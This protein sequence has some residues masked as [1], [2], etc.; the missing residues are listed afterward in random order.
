MAN[1]V[2]G[3]LMCASPNRN[4]LPIKFTALAQRYALQKRKQKPSNKETAKLSVLKT[5]NVNQVQC[6]AYMHTQR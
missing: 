6:D 3:L 5:K 2:I 1:N 4:H